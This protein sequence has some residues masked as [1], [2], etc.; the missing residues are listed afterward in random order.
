[1]KRLFFIL[2][3]GLWGAFIALAF[4]SPET[5]T[6]IWDWTLGLWWPLQIT[7]W[8]LFLP[9]MVGLWVWQ[10]DWSF[11]ARLTIVAVLAVGWS[12]ASFPRR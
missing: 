12:A 3:V 6:Q 5:L 10:T 4:T 7:V 11:A 1:M 8:I 2:M 9:W